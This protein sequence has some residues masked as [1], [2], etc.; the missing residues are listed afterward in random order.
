[1][2]FTEQHDAIRRTVSRFVED[3]LN[4]HVE[5]WEEA[6]IMPGHEIMK[7]AGDLG[8]LGID[9]PEAYGGLGLDFSY[10]AVF[11]EELGGADHGSS[12]L[13]IG[14]LLILP[15]LL[16]IQVG[17]AM[18]HEEREVLYRRI[19]Y[20]IIAGAAVMGLPIWEG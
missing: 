9:K 3:E 5:A 6:G 15:N 12:P 14:V 20:S 19:A 13:L 7:K 17:A 16:A 2:Q 11:S 18:F 1:M 4:P 8:L 10:Q